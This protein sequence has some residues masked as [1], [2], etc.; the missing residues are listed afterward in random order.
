MRLS[1]AAGLLGSF[2]QSH[3]V[4]H[5]RRGGLVGGRTAWNARSMFAHIR[6]VSRAATVGASPRRRA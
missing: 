4:G 2:S 1:V 6:P 3:R 5:L